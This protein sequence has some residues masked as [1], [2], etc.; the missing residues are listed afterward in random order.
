MDE[1]M[2]PKNRKLKI[3]NLNEYI[4]NWLCLRQSDLSVILIGYYFCICY[5][6]PLPQAAAPAVCQS[7][8]G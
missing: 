8:G 5:S 7:D 2:D 4:N 1:N 3:K 6:H